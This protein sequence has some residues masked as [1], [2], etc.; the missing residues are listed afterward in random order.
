MS[1][2]TKTSSS[3]QEH[4]KKILTREHGKSQFHVP[5]PAPSCSECLEGLQS[6]V[7]FT[8]NLKQM[9]GAGTHAADRISSL[10]VGTSYQEIAGQFLVL[11]QHLDGAMDSV[12]SQIKGELE[13]CIKR[14][15]RD[16]VDTNGKTDGNSPR[17]GH[18]PEDL[19]V[20]IL[21]NHSG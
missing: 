8:D 18:K 21:Y 5:M 7:C 9:C 10:L 16:E 20:C 12:V 11:Q 13:V 19:Q 1:T 2:K 3:N 4:P 15:G 6:I 14:L 17:Q